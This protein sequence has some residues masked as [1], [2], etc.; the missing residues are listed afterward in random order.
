MATI[1]VHIALL[2]YAA[3]AA[4]FL[5]WLVRPDRR[6]VSAGRALLLAGVA[7]HFAA[8]AA[9]L[10]VAALG[11][12]AGVWKSGQ[13]FSLLAA[14]TVAGYLLLDWR[15]DLPVAGA[16]VAPFTVAV[17]GPAHL[18]TS[19]ER[20]VPPQLYHSALPFLHLRAPALGTGIPPLPF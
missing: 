4:A 14:V 16:F 5:T 6:W 3:G 1:L 19:Q 18:V 11:L 20:A 2:A 7:V 17:M 13:L 12:G 15:Y 8:F 10:G 9:G